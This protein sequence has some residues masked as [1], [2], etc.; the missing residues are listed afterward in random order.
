MIRHTS[1]M[2][3]GKRSE[4]PLFTVFIRYSSQ[5]LSAKHRC[6]HWLIRDYRSTASIAYLVSN[7][8]VSMQLCLATRHQQHPITAY[9]TCLEAFEHQTQTSANEH[10]SCSKSVKRWGEPTVWSQVIRCKSQLNTWWKLSILIT[11]SSQMSSCWQKC[12][13]D[14]T[15]T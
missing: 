4:A 7:P 6:H 3:V 5:I 8:R 10:L 9:F 2:S 11:T 15:F 14:N 12:V 13:R 1:H